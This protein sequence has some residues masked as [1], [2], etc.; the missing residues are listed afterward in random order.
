MENAGAELVGVT[1]TATCCRCSDDE[2]VD[3]NVGVIEVKRERA[4]DI[5][6][7]IEG[8]IDS[9]TDVVSVY[10]G[11]GVRVCVSKRVFVNDGDPDTEA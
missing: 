11:D 6:I 4:L 7:K 5:V 8:V 9:D 2:G 10:D 1:A 3:E